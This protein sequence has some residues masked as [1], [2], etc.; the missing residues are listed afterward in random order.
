MADKTLHTR[1]W[2]DLPERGTLTMLRLIH[3]T[4]TAVG[5]WAARLLLYPT[6]LYFVLS[7]HTARRMSY[8][9]LERVRSRPAHWWHVFRHFHCFAATI[10][11]RVYLLTGAFQHFEIEFHDREILHQQVE[12][13]Q[14]CILLGSHLGSFEVLRALGVTLAEFPLKV[15][16]DVVH[17]ENITRYLDA[18][19]PEI[20]SSVMS[21]VSSITRD[22]H[23]TIGLTFIRFGI[24]P[25]VTQPFWPWG[26]RAPCPLIVS[27]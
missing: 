6:T 15:L 18:L 3:W 8:Q 2:T 24:E 23:L 13:G 11:D 12:S 27:S 26:Q 20:A 1:R 4:A 7:A 22:L 9:Y 14:G 19:N 25:T 10:L 5:R 21:I 17:N 16:M